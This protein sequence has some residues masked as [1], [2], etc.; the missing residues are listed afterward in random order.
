MVEEKSVTLQDVVSNGAEVSSGGASAK[1]RQCVENCVS[2]FEVKVD[3]VKM[4]QNLNVTS[5]EKRQNYDAALLG[6]LLLTFMTAYY[7]VNSRLDIVRRQ[8]W[9]LIVNATAIFIAVFFYASM[10]DLFRIAFSLIKVTPEEGGSTEAG[11]A[12]VP[13]SGVSLVC[14]LVC[15]IALFVV[16][17]LTLI[18]NRRSRLRL[19]IWGTIGGHMLGFAVI[20]LFAGQL[21][22]Y[23]S[24]GECLAMHFLILLI[25]MIVVPILCLPLYRIAVYTPGEADE[26]ELLQSCIDFF[27]MGASFIIAMICRGFI[28]GKVAEKHVRLDHPFSE[29]AS[30]FAAGLCFLVLGLIVFRCWE[31]WK[32]EDELPFVVQKLM[33]V[34][35]QTLLL[36]TSWCF[37]EALEWIWLKEFPDHRVMGRLMV[38]MS[39]GTLFVIC[40]F[41][42]TRVS[43]AIEDPNIET[44]LQPVYLMMSLLVGLSWE[45]TYD[46]ALEQFVDRVSSNEIHRKLLQILLNTFVV[47][48]F[49]P[50]FGLYMLPAHNDKLNRFYGDTR[51]SVWQICFDLPC[52]EST[53]VGEVSEEDL[54]PHLAVL[55]PR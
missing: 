33:K 9:D 35:V 47:M 18:I 41:V 16:I 27:V 54:K 22:H 8:T 52:D 25:Y 29:T 10:M 6:L 26:E 21:A 12:E 31:V 40:L 14:S 19:K 39:A 13:V 53:E 43:I 30:L 48:I 37:L 3:C 46:A 1:F 28:M 4:C 32:E 38:A 42:L 23:G 51:F 5:T 55:Q 20:D 50:G 36:T 17:A 2:L 45:K 24:F 49:L 7:L 44:R 11:G 34:L 15:F